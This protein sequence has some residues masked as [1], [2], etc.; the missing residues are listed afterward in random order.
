M[1]DE[2]PQEPVLVLQPKGRLDVDSCG[3]LRKQLAAA[4]A[5]GVQSVGIDFS[6]VTFLDQT[7]VGLLAGAARHL[8]KRGGS[9]V[10]LRAVGSVAMSLRING[11]DNLARV[12]PPA[13]KVLPGSG[14]GAPRTRPRRLAAVQD[15]ALKLPG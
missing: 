7:G 12:R 9:L 14:S 5:G 13:L 4:F 15:P 8:R 1:I 6:G 2:R 10:V 3:D 11:L